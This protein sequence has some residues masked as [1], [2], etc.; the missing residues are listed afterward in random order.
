MPIWALIVISH[1]SIHALVR[2]N[3]S[4]RHSSSR[5]YDDEVSR[6]G[7]KIEFTTH[8]E[9]LNERFVGLSKSGHDLTPLLPE[10]IESLK[11]EQ[12]D[13]DQNYYDGLFLGAGHRGLY[14]ARLGG[15]P[16]FSS[17]CRIDDKCS[18]DTLVF[19][20]ACDDDHII[21]TRGGQVIDVRCGQIIG[22]RPE[23]DGLF[24]VLPSK[25]VFY[26]LSVALPPRS[27][28]ENFWG[29]RVNTQHG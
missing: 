6:K 12:C 28:P 26:A 10:E 4:K 24:H 21:V 22:E 15:I 7:I 1:V 23:K 2:L 13:E 5:L 19:D 9:Y 8:E 27:Q 17:G 29:R 11:E 25:L 18:K 14:C 3:F 16:L 20:E